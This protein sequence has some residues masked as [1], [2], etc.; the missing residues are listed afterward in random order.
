MGLGLLEILGLREAL[1]PLSIMGISLLKLPFL[2]LLSLH[3]ERF[4][5][6]LPVS[7]PLPCGLPPMFSAHFEAL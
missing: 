7:P 3:L 4:H 5:V 2:S 1:E 6:R